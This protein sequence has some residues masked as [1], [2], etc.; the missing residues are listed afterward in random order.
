VNPP[1]QPSDA[2]FS[3]I[4]FVEDVRILELKAFPVPVL[5]N[6]A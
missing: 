1:I 5:I 3:G 4:L 2:P 6:S